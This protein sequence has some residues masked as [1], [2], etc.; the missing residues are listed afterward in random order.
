MTC[1]NVRNECVVLCASPCKCYHLKYFTAS[2]HKR[3]KTPK[4]AESDGTSADKRLTS[5]ADKS[6]AAEVSALRV[7]KQ[8]SSEVCEQIITDII[9]QETRRLK[10]KDVSSRQDGARNELVGILSKVMHQQSDE[11]TRCTDEPQPVT[12]VPTEKVPKNR[13]AK[14]YPLSESNVTA[15]AEQIKE[16]TTVK[17]PA[18]TGIDEIDNEEGRVQDSRAAT[19][20]SSEVL[21]NIIADLLRRVYIADVLQ[22]LTVEQSPMSCSSI[23]S[24]TQGAEKDVYYSHSMSSNFLES[25]M[26]EIVRNIRMDQSTDLI[27]SN[28]EQINISSSDKSLLGNVKRRDFV[29]KEEIQSPRLI[30]SDQMKYQLET[31]EIQKPNIAEV[32]KSFSSDIIQQVIA[33]MLEAVVANPTHETHWNES[34]NTAMSNSSRILYKIIDDI[35]R[36]A[37]EITTEVNSRS[38]TLKKKE[39]RRE[40]EKEDGPKERSTNH[41][42]NETQESVQ[43]VAKEHIAGQSE[44]KVSK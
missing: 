28:F 39:Q 36:T 27:S 30:S 34:E 13:S 20:I 41:E 21:S 19:T 10:A 3:G 29:P 8:I 40:S 23:A 5:D 24:E 25:V 35:L 43:M 22:K 32:I 15:S 17:T 6:I 33:D 1:M 38:E 12:T 4:E 11:Y 16:T 7:L 26:S 9:T 44:D 42:P 37:Q 14:S 2:Q 31:S 18:R